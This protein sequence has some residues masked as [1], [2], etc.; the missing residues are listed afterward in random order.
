MAEPTRHYDF[1]LAGGGAAGLSLAYRLKRS[2][3]RDASILI[4]DRQ[5]KNRNDHTW[6]SWLREPDPF[7]AVAY[8]T[9]GHLTFHS[10]KEE[11]PLVLAPYRY[12]MLRS[13]DFYRFTR[14]A[15]AAQPGVDFLLG[16]VERIVDGP[17]CAEVWA[18]ELVFSGDWVF[19]SRYGASQ[20]CPANPRYHNLLQHFLGWEIETPVAAFDPDTPRMFDFRTP[21]R[22]AMRFCY[23]LPYAP[24]RALVEYTLFS[25]HSLPLAEY[26]DALRT[27]IRD[28]LHIHEYR[29]LDE[30]RAAIPMTDAP[31]P[32]RAGRRV[33]ATGT[34][35]GRVKGSTGYAFQRIQLDS[36]AIVRS[37]QT[38][39]HPFAV[40]TP[41]RRYHTF[42][43]LLLHI[44]ERRGGLGAPI[45]TA[46][47][48]NNSIHRL[49]RFLDEEGTLWE[50]IRLMASVPSWP[51]VQAWGEV[52]LKNLSDGDGRG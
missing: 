31:F 23:V 10:G 9:W 11:L 36:A 39:G 19:D 8:R 48:K 29:I 52:I 30:E 15:L 16:D 50:N 34:R 22:G 27:Y 26:A 51:F 14:E 32:R 35:G 25:A 38:H 4:V 42:D 28:V 17:T 41:P 20:D 3:L 43:T 21:Q 40:P 47:F 7:D 18:N 5:V 45:F 46:L 1:I 13:Y 33:M 12:R 6:C 24:D 2:S 44:L 37:L 49:F